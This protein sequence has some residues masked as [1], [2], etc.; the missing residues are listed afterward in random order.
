MRYARAFPARADEVSCRTNCTD[1]AE[2][3][4]T[5]D[6]RMQSIRNLI[7]ENKGKRR[8]NRRDFPSTLLSFL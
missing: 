1:C 4:A 8:K 7:A 5:L 3:S 2:Q 6:K